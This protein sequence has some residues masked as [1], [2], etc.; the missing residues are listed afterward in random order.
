[1][2]FNIFVAV[3]NERYI[4]QNYAALKVQLHYLRLYVV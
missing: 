3:Y 2:N 4:H 1:M